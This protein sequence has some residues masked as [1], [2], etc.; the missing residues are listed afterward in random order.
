LKIKSFITW[1]MKRI[2]SKI[3]FTKNVMFK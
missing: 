2:D 1:A 3:V